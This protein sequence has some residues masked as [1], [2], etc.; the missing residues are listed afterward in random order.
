MS[1]GAPFYKRSKHFGMEF[2]MFREYILLKEML[3]QHMPTDELIADVLTK[4]FAPAK[5]LVF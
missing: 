3:I 4:P 2:D 5:F 1:H